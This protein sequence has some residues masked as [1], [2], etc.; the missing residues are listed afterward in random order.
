MQYWPTAEELIAARVNSVPKVVA[1]ATLDAAPWGE[2][3]PARVEPDILRHLRDQRDAG[4][5]VLVWGSL[6]LSSSLL[7]EG[8]LDELDL[9]VS[10]VLLGAGTPVV[11]TSDAVRLGQVAS[12]DWGTVTHLRYAVGG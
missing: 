3:A 6:A 4:A 1:S 11:A 7:A 2:H 12:E 8:L 9:F 10:P 5:T